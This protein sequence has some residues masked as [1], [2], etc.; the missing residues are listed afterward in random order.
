[1]NIEK[2]SN[3]SFPSVL[4]STIPSWSQRS[5]A[6][7]FS[8][9]FEG[10]PPDKLANVY[11]R[12]DLPTSKVAGR[13]FR[14]LE[15][16][17]MKSVFLPC[18]HTGEEIQGASPKDV[19]RNAITERKKYGFFTKHRLSLFLWLREL[20]WKFGKWKS[21]ELK[22]FIEDV[23]PEVF[24]FHIESYRYFNRLNKYLIDEIK[25]NKV[26]AY[27]WDDNFTYKQN[28]K[29][30]SAKIERYFLRKQV[31]D[32]IKKSDIVLSISPKMKE[33]CDR[34]FGI[35][36][37]LMTKPILSENASEY[38]CNPDSP[39]RIVYSGSLVIGRDSSVA[40]LVE[41]LKE[42]KKERGVRFVLDIYSG[43]ALSDE[44]K[45]LLK[46]P[47][48]SFFHGHI[49]QDKVFKKQE[50]ADILL[51]AENLDNKIY[52]TARLSFS[53]KITDYLS[54]NRAIMAIAPRDIAPTE[55]LRDQNAA[56]I[57][58][59]KKEIIDT[60]KKIDSEPK[61]LEKYAKS[62]FDCGK[63]NHSKNVI[64]SKFQ[65]LLKSQE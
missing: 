8:T 57:C 42:I 12:A 62:A 13:Y 21:K 1:M 10:Y 60:L 50:E 51:F 46:D 64:L 43:T 58:A 11:V 22:E 49:P 56:M 52:N 6:N 3:T 45:S 33:E 7:T 48:V 29:G 15:G 24:V 25:P 14:I 63:R 27:L 31:R 47:D 16:A 28:T 44:K 17:V 38:T 61:I 23:N 4:V 41:C 30:L 40:L 20:G 19:D 36:S 9:L 18:V 35:K 5:G 59:S 34:E 65:D 53:T 37:I 55:Y 32:L 26:I 54:R 39:I 2:N